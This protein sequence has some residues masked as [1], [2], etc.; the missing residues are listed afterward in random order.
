MTS[1]SI[2]KHRSREKVTH[3]TVAALF[4]ALICITTAFI[5]HI[6]FGINGGYI[7]LGDTLI[8][9]SAA[10]L[11]MPY[12]MAAGA[13]GGAL[14]D[15][16][17]APLWM[18]ATFIIKAILPIMFTNKKATIINIQNVAAIFGA[19]LVSIVGYYIAEVILYGSEAALFASVT[20]S[21]IQATGSGILFIVVGLAFDKMKFKPKF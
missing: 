13:I 1:Q 19:G 20:S 15:L 12:A 8:Y 5:F 14:A 9:L 17:T 21:L 7:H 4:A 11:P 16:L 2:T 3:L 10:L 18:P 6:P